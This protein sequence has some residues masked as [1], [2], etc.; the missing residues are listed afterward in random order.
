MLNYFNENYHFY[1]NEYVVYYC[2]K[3]DARLKCKKKRIKFFFEKSQKSAKYE[4]NVKI[5]VFT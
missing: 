5:M 1:I 3:S 4:T 2:Q